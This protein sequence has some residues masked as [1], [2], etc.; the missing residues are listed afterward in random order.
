MEIIGLMIMVLGFIIGVGS[1]MI[2]NAIGWR[3]VFVII[4]IAVSYYG[5][6]GFIIKTHR[7]RLFPDMK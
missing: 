1:L 4:G 3:F 7:K 6:H 5:L 2:T